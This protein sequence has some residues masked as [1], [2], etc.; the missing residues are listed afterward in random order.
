MRSTFTGDEWGTI[1]PYLK[2]SISPTENCC[3]HM[4]LAC[5][6]PLMTYQGLVYY[7]T[8]KRHNKEIIARQTTVRTRASV[9][10]SAALKQCCGTVIGNT[11]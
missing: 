4:A 6:P 11:S 9:E 2:Y 10:S 7:P 5:F 1:F 3:V 8:R